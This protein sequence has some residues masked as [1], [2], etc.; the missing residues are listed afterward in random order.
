MLFRSSLY[1][2]EKKGA[3]PIHHFY[4]APGDSDP[5][6]EILK[7]LKNLLG[8]SGSIVAYYATFEKGILKGASEVYPQFSNWFDDIEHRV[9]DLL[10]P[11]RKFLYYHP[12]QAGSNSLKN[13]LP[14]IT[15]NTYE[16]ME[17]T[18]GAKASSEYYRVTFNK[19]VD[20]KDRRLVRIALKKYCDLDTRGMIDILETLMK[21]VK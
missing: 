9:V 7:Q 15:E 12:R 1:V 17:I 19:D 3:E 14:A 6:L 18:N 4:I 2:V 10:E 8:N 20:E 5:R 21:E 16:E 11:F 13:V